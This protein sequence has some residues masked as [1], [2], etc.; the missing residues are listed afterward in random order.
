MAPL[1]D[2][3]KLDR[4]GGR[5]AWILFCTSMMIVTLITMAMVDFVE[6][7][8]VLVWM[9]LLNNFFVQRRMSLSIP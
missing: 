2:I 9:V 4:F 6:H 7:Y 5:K 3:I 8:R 1:V